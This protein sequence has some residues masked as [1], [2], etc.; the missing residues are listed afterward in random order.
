MIKPEIVLALG[1]L[2]GDDMRRFNRRVHDLIAIADAIELIDEIRNGMIDREQQR[3]TNVEG[4][5]LLGDAR[6]YLLDVLEG[7]Y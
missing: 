4:Y 6:L 1:M 2:I 3:I 7:R 5:R